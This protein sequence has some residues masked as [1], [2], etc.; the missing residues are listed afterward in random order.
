M[1]KILKKGHFIIIA[2]IHAIQ[3]VEH[4]TPPIHQ[5]MQRVLAQH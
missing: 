2:H 1:E 4:V 3:N 5:D